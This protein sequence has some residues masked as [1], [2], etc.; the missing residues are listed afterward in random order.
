MH[1][2]IQALLAAT[3]FHQSVT[4]FLDLAQIVCLLFGIPKIAQGAWSFSRGEFKEGKAEIIAG[5]LLA[6]SV[7]IVRMFAGWLGVNL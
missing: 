3:S 2:S 5:F 4:S 7:V 1:A 6:M